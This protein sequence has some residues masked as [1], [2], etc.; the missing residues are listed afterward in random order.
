VAAIYTVAIDGGGDR[1]LTPD[2]GTPD[3][4]PRWSPDGRKIVCERGQGSIW[5]IDGDG[6][7]ATELTSGPYDSQPAWQPI[8]FVYC[9][10][11]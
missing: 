3:T 1:L 4:A 5:T 8:P 2:D 7:N 10:A 11:P 9:C 6:R